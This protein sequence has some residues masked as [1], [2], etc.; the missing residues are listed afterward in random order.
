M[1]VMGTPAR[2]RALGLM[3]GLVLVAGLSACGD[4]DAAPEAGMIVGG[5]PIGSAAG[6]C[7]AFDEDTLAAQEFAFD[8]TLTAA[9]ADGEQATFEVHQWFRG[10]EGTTA[11]YGA[12]GLLST[13]AQALVG[14]SLVVGERYLISG[15]DGFVWACGYSLTYDTAVA[16]EWAEVFGA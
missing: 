16:A 14:T 3:L 13:E 2:R 9:S 6:D 5:E 12:G 11:T 7:L 15:S 8:G 1:D 10:G 4:D